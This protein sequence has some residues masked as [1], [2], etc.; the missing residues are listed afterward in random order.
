MKFPRARLWLIAGIVFLLVS[1]L[2]EIFLKGFSKDFLIL[3]NSFKS[4]ISYGFLMVW[5]FYEMENS[6]SQLSLLSINKNNFPQKVTEYPERIAVF[7]DSSNLYG[8][9]RD[10]LES[11]LRI[12]Q[13]TYKGSVPK[14]GV[15]FSRKKF[16]PVCDFTNDVIGNRNCVFKGYYIGE[17]VY[18][19]NMPPV[20]M[21]TQKNRKEQENFFSL[22]VRNGFSIRKGRVETHYKFE[23]ITQKEKGVDTLMT[24]DILEGAL[25]DTYDR[26]VVISSDN[27]FYP[28]L[29]RVKLLGKK[30]EYISLGKNESNLLKDI[31][32]ETRVIKYKQYIKG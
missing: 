1:G 32:D 25:L 6:Y 23:K 10:D 5:L 15:G 24:M 9:V 27:D 19:G 20:K 26:A 3:F 8:I 29:N 30:V 7:I 13:G 11:D 28:V 12:K 14:N 31:S 16:F 22:L 17:V 2:I 21:Y 18:N 4:I